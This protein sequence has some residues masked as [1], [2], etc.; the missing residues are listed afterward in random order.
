[1]RTTTFN[2]AMRDFAT[3]TDAMNRTFGQNVAAYDFARNGGYQGKNSE[4][5]SAKLRLPVDVWAKDDA[6]VITAYVPGVN[7]ENVDITVEGEELTIRG[8]FPTP[9]TQ[10]G[11]KEAGVE[12]LKGELYHGTFERRMTFNVPVNVEAIEA[13][14]AHG[15]LTLRVPKAEAV[16]PKQIKVV[17]K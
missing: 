13:T 12:F 17:V 4:T 16:R 11:A 14:Y 9:F 5:Q 7:P 15:L 6:F 10:E 3:I 1:M 8:E 2:N